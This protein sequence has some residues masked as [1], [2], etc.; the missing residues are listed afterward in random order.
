MQQLQNKP[1]ARRQPVSMFARIIYFR[2]TEDNIS[3]LIQKLASG[4]CIFPGGKYEKKDGDI[5]ETVRRELREE[6]MLTWPRFTH[7]W[8]I[9]DLLYS[10]R[11]F[12]VRW[13]N[14]LDIYFVVEW[15]DWE[16]QKPVLQQRPSDEDSKLIQETR[17][18]NL[19][20]VVKEESKYRKIW[21]RNII[22]ACIKA[23]N[24]IVNWTDPA[25]DGWVTPVRVGN[26][27][28]FSENGTS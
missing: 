28:S 19:N 20:E 4:R 13:K 18:V 10:S 9:Q 24:I 25:L 17:W 7:K 8:L 2:K 3:V 14:N 23:Y 27:W 21:Y 16:D 11:V 6:T 1:K 5:I 12:E 22:T 15:R 26:T